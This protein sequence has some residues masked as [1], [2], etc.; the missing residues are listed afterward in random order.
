[1]STPYSDAPASAAP[2]ASRFDPK[3]GIPYAQCSDCGFIA[4]SKAEIS[5]H[6]AATMT[7]TGATA[8]ITSRSHGYRV[9]NPSREEALQREVNREAGDAIESAASEFV[10]SVYRLH[11]RDGVPL[12]ELTAAVTKVWE[13]VDFTEAW[14]EYIEDDE[15]DEDDDSSDETSDAQLHQETA[16]FEVSE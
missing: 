12:A 6:A 11:M 10:E 3:P 15:D 16:L 1:M 7:E 4:A 5:E 8:G 2:P 13:S 9:T 14:A